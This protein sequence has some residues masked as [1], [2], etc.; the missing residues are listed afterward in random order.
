MKCTSFGMGESGVSVHSVSQDFS[1]AMQSRNSAVK[2][3]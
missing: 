1:Q 2:L 3:Y